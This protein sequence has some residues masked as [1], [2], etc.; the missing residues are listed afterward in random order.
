VIIAR[1]CQIRGSGFQWRLRHAYM[2]LSGISDL[3]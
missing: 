3:Q 2:H 1:L